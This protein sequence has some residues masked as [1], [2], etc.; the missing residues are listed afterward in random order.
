MK[1]QLKSLT[2]KY[3][4]QQK[5]EEII[6]FF[7]DSWPYFCGFMC[8]FS[9]MA[10]FIG[11]CEESSVAIVIGICLISFWILIGIIALA[12]KISKWL[13]DNYEKATERVKRDLKRKKI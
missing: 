6:D 11:I 9:L 4:W 7:E 2:W 5:K 10:I 12:K 1:S 8:F 3:F 13:Q